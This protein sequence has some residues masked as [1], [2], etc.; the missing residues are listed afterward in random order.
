MGTILLPFIGLWF[1]SVA[2]GL[3][4]PSAV[5]IGVEALAI[6][7]T[8][9]ERWGL[10]AACSALLLGFHGMLATVWGGFVV[11]VADLTLPTELT[12]LRISP[13]VQLI[14]LGLLVVGLTQLGNPT[15][16]R[17]RRS[18]RW[19][20]IVAGTGIGAGGFLALWLP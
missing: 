19:W 18:L 7:D 14:G 20:L 1:G 16:T 9:H 12:R 4:L 17:R 5:L 11:V 15:L 10:A 2:V 3:I 8:R 6:V 13:P